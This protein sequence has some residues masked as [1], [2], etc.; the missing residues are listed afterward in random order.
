VGEPLVGGYLNPYKAAD[1]VLQGENPATN[2]VD[3][4]AQK[5]TK[6]SI[7]QICNDVS[8]IMAAFGSFPMN[9]VPYNLTGNGAPNSN[10][11]VHY[12]LGF[13]PDLGNV[14][15]SRR[16]IGWNTPITLP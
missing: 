6:L 10:S 1:G 14:K 16:A 2:A 9:T 12:L 15:H 11:F 8:A 3:F 4:D 13:A 5:N 7:D